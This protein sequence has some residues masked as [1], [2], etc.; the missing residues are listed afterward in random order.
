ML[1]YVDRI[2]LVVADRE[3]AVRTWQDL[4]GAEKTAEGGSRFLNAHRTTVRAGATDFEFL[5]PAGPGPVQDFADRRGQGLYGAGF[6]TPDLG[7]MARHFD[8]HEVPFTEENG[9]LYL[10]VDATHGMPTVISA[11]GSRE[12][13]GHIRHAYEVT[14]PVPDWQDTAAH[15]T[16]IFGLDPTRY[17]H[18]QSHNY[19]YDGTLTL[20]NPPDRLDRIEITQTLGE[21]AMDR[22]FRKHGPSLY[23]CYIETDDVLALADGLKAHGARYEHSD[24]SPEV[25]LFIHPS[26]LYGMLMGVSRTNFAWVWSGRPELAGEGAQEIHPVD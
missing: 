17:S 10:S 19:G 6:S 14:N 12:R 21:G 20:F 8:S 7:V 24:R 1:S 4:F 26:A 25:G 15:Y 5:E 11:D 18:I 9:Q 13:I 3:A 23:M 16:R 22:F 2:Q